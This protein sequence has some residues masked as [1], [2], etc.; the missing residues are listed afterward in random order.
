MI[1]APETQSTILHDGIRIINNTIIGVKE[2]DCGIT[3]RNARN[4]E[5]LN[6]KVE[7]CKK[8]IVLQSVEEV[9]ME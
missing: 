1:S 3:V 9:V 7:G 5:L 8:D 2:N 4:I 6:N